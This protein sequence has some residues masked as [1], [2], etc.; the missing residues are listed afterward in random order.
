MCRDLR[1]VVDQDWLPGRYLPASHSVILNA[2][3]MIVFSTQEAGSKTS[4]FV[5][6]GKGK[7]GIGGTPF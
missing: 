6:W 2:G 5:L 3:Q 7:Y 1:L 4:H